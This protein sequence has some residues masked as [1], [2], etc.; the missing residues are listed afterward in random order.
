M[1]EHFQIDEDALDK[2]WL[3]QPSIV[4]KYARRQAS[5]RHELTLAKNKYEAI[6]AETRN[7]IRRDPTGYG[8]AKPTETALNDAVDCAA[9]VKAA[10]GEIAD[11]QFAFDA[12][13]AA[14]TALDH[15]KKALEN[16]VDLLAM[17][18]YSSPRYKN[19]E[20]AETAKKITQRSV[21]RPIGTRNSDGN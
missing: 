15:K 5:A 16:L 19:R 13:C 21:R 14:M 10:Q 17:D 4:A 20:S 18:Y 9:P 8:L 6:R 2:E 11:L 7:K 12:C 3:K 1:N